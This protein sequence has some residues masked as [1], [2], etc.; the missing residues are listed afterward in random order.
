MDNITNE[1]ARRLETTHDDATRAEPANPA[2]ARDVRF[3]SDAV[4]KD[5]DEVVPLV[6][7]EGGTDAISVMGWT[8]PRGSRASFAVSKGLVAVAWFEGAGRELDVE[9]FIRRH[10]LGHTKVIGDAVA[11]GERPASIV[12]FHD[13]LFVA[14]RPT[15]TETV[16][17]E[18]EIPSLKVIDSYRHRRAS[19][20][21]HHRSQL[22]V[23][24]PRLLLLD[25]GELVEL[26][27][28]GI[29]GVNYQ[30]PTHEVDADEIAVRWRNPFL[31]TGGL[32]QASLRGDFVPALG[33]TA[34]CTPAWSREGA[35]WPGPAFEPFPMLACAVAGGGVQVVRLPRPGKSASP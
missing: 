20:S 27:D 21:R 24:G 26:H 16:V 23:E 34:S 14:T 25:R 3:P 30:P 22:F 4:L 10:H 11:A 33:T 31:T 9:L 1:R 19:S 15:P 13:R 29:G 6:E 17:S 35:A 28:Y 2:P 7:A 18:L 12:F 8:H 5:G 32:D